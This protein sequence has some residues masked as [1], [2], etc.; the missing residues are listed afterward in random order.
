MLVDAVPVQVRSRDG[1]VGGRGGVD[2]IGLGA[3]GCVQFA[4]GGGQPAGNPDH[5]LASKQQ[6]VSEPAGEPAAVFDGPGGGAV[7]DRP[8]PLQQRDDQECIVLDGQRRADGPAVTPD[9][10]CNVN[11][12]VRVDPHCHHRDVLSPAIA[13][14]GTK[15]RVP[16]GGQTY[17]ELT[18]QQASIKSLPV[19]VLAL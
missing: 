10:H 3:G 17:C 19:R 8:D 9:G 5:L 7:G 1:G 18:A 11:M 15:A 2:G 6:A 16:A 4:V 12:L 13:D 14:D